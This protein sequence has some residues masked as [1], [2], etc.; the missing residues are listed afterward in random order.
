M[1]KL[2]LDVSSY[3]KEG[4]LDYQKIVTE[5]G[6][7]GVIIRIGYTGYGKSKQKRI[8]PMF[9]KHYE[10]F[11]AMGIPIGVYWYSCATTDK[12]AVEEAEKVIAHLGDRKLELPI[13]FD[14]ED[15]H[16]I[17]HIMN[18]PESQATIGKE[19]LTMVAKAFCKRI[20]EH[21]HRAGI[22]ASTSWFKNKLNL[23]EL[24]LYSIWVAH[25]GVDKPG[26]EKPDIWQFTSSGRIVG[27]QGYLDLNRCFVDLVEKPVEKDYVHRYEKTFGKFKLTIELRWLP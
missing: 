6:V 17:K 20:E 8:D 3:Q 9:A 12:E 21:G 23:D 13:Y 24:R 19:R 2:Y 18:A 1:E 25:Y 22:Y 16:D 27:A 11:D 7:E 14:T 5:G 10:G 4:S 26:I 15:N